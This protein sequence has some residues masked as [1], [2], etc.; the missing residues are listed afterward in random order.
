MKP[1]VTYG[2]I[3]RHRGQYPVSIMCQLFGVSRSGYYDFVHRL[4]RPEPDEKLAELL[5]AQQGRCRQTYGYRRMWLWLKKQGIHRS[6]KTVLRIMKNM[7]YLQK[8]AE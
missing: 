6:P 7:I 4:D 8:S 5:Q 3:Y 1:K 2:V